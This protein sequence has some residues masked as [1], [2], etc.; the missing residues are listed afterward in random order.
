M[1]D[2]TCIIRQHLCE[3][4]YSIEWQINES[5]WWI[6]SYH[7]SST[8]SIVV[9]MGGVIFK[10]RER[11][12]CM[13]SLD[14]YKEEEQEWHLH[15][16]DKTNNRYQLLQSIPIEW[17]QS[18]GNINVFKCRH[19]S[20]ILDINVCD[21]LNQCKDGSDELVCNNVCNSNGN[22]CF[23]NCSTLKCNCNDSYFQSMYSYIKAM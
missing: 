7:K 14:T 16:C 21:G 12:Y 9:F 1:Y 15:Q 11:F 5:I 4:S 6:P 10:S 19:S 2:R 18:C 8:I 17:N 3:D 20:C 13:S 22:N 23:N